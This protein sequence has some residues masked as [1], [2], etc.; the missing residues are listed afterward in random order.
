MGIGPHPSNI[1]ICDGTRGQKDGLAE[2]PRL[3]GAKREVRRWMSRP[4][5]SYPGWHHW[6]FL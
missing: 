3:Q 2:N 4:V 1:V 5:R 6:T